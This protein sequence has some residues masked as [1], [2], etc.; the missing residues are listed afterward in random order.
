MCSPLLSIEFPVGGWPPLATTTTTSA[1]AQRNRTPAPSRTRESDDDP[2]A[3]AKRTP[4]TRSVWVANTAWSCRSCVDGLWRV[5]GVSPPVAFLS[6]P[7]ALVSRRVAAKL[8]LQLCHKSCLFVLGR[9]LSAA[10]RHVS[11]WENKT[12][13]AA[14]SRFTHA[15]THAQCETKTHHVPLTS[16]LP[17]GSSNDLFST[18]LERMMIANARVRPTNPCHDWVTRH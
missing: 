8:T 17:L 9:L 6:P 12:P 14:S 18:S 7:L 13:G 2:A 11:K 4:C 5:V 16:F 10:K 3:I 1:S 15:R